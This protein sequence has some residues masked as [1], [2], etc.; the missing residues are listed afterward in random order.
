MFLTYKQVQ[1]ILK[2]PGSQILW[3]FLPSLMESQERP[4]GMRLFIHFYFIPC[5]Q[6]VPTTEQTL[7]YVLHCWLFLT[8]T[9]KM[10]GQVRVIY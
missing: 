8:L 6:V 3:K 10:G 4:Y 1:L 9:R 5:T 7:R 2:I